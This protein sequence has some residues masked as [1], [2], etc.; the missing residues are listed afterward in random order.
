MQ[1]NPWVRKILRSRKWQPTPVFLPG[2]FHGQRSQASYNRRDRHDL[3]TEH[4]HMRAC[5]LGHVRLC[6]PVDFSPPDSSVHGSF[7]EGM[8]ERAATSSA[9]GSS[10]PGSN[11]VS[12]AGRQVPDHCATWGARARAHTQKDHASQR[13]RQPRPTRWVADSRED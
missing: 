5:V 4:T 7:Q 8:L 6:N 13:S 11:P 2:K 1:L 10:D 12:C 3:A 9:R